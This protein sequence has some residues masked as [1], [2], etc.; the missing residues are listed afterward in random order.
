MCVEIP[1]YIKTRQKISEGN[2]G[3]V[4]SQEHIEKFGKANK[5]KECT[6]ETRQKLRGPRGPQKNPRTKPFT[7]EH[8]QKLSEAAKNRYK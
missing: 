7:E 8:K 3:K 4:L 6:E 2:K 1:L 5:G